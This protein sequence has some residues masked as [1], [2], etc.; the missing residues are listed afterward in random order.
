[1]QPLEVVAVLDEALAQLVEQPRMRR[2]IERRQMIGRIGSGSGASQLVPSARAARSRGS[3]A[4][5][6][7]ARHAEERRAA[8]GPRAINSGESW[9]GL[10]SNRRR[11]ALAT[12]SE[13]FRLHPRAVRPSIGHPIAATLIPFQ[14]EAPKAFVLAYGCTDGGCRL[15]LTGDLGSRVC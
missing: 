3:A 14:H 5:R 7:S 15:T 2:R 11:V 12:T 6:K 9:A 10:R 13:S 1:M 8:A 4:S